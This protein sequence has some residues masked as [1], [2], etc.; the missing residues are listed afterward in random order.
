MVILAADI[1]T[2]ST[3]AAVVD[4]AGRV[5]SWAETGNRVQRPEPGAAEHD[6]EHLYRNF[7]AVCRRVAAR[8][9]SRI[10]AVVLSGYQF[11]LLPLDARKR[12]LGGMTTLLDTRAGETFGAFSRRCDFERLYRETGCTPSAIYPLP[13]LFW[14]RVRRP[15]L[16]RRARYFAGGK[17]YVTWRLTGI[18]ATEPS[19]SSATQMLDIRRRK[20]SPYALRLAGVPAG[21]LPVVVPAGRVLGPLLP[22][23]A[24][25]LGLKA[26]VVLV[27]G[28]YDAAALILGIGGLESGVGA[29][30]LGTTAMLRAVARRPLH[31][32]Y[33]KRLQT[34]CFDEGRWLAGAGINNAGNA[35]AWMVKRFG[36]RRERELDGLAARAPR[37]AGGV[38]FLPY[39]S[40]E[41]DPRIGSAATGV[42]SGL[43]EEHSAAHLA[44]ALLEGVG[45]TVRLVRD[46]LA[47]N[48][49]RLREVRA[50]GGGAKSRLWIRVLADMLGVPVRVA[51]AGHPSLVGGAQL[52]FVATGRYAS[53][54]EAARRMVRIGRPVKPDPRCVALYGREA[55]RFESLIRRVFG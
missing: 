25:R 15:R 10:G 40:G 9:R 43:R 14:L 37:G 29:L 54:A 5:L 28:V 27:P 24:A 22:R 46:A 44:M 36:L 34:Y 47:E 33:G 31:D 21:S 18:L 41:R 35:L 38:F 52:G 20:W 50:G 7:A 53:L 11:G 19:L 42:I 26:G 45:Y 23:A 16:F 51:A 13:R 49:V 55:V 8:H 6:P 39:L 1:G 32:R 12:P 17:D 3:K 48:G 2:T 4:D 30:N